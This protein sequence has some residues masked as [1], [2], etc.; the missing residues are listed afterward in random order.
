MITIFTLPKPFIGSYKVIQL[1]AIMSWQ[2]LHPSPEIILCG[3]EP[4]TAELCVRHGWL[5]LPDIYVNEYGTPRLDHAFARVHAVAQNSLLC[6]V[7]ADII[8]TSNFMMAVQRIRFGR[9]LMVGRRWNLNQVDSIDFTVQDWEDHLKAHV[10]REGVLQPPLGSD[11]FVFKK[12]TLGELPPFVVGRPGWDNWMIYHARILKMPVIDATQA[13]TVIHQNHDYKH[14]PGGSNLNNYLGPEADQN[15]I[16]MG[17]NRTRFTL[18]DATHL[19]TEQGLYPVR[20][21]PYIKRRIQTLA[22]LHPKLRPLA[23]GIKRVLRK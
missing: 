6:Y 8:L 13:C 11:Y 12:G 3:N 22:S 2:K 21:F 20:G 5:H 23:D 14:V 15:L 16:V 10:G 9:F 17:G 19:L 7:N 18:L 4:G 1:N